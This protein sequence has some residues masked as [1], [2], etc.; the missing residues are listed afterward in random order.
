MKTLLHFWLAFLLLFAQGGA[1]VH[2]VSHLAKPAPYRSLQDQQPADTFACEACL[3]Y[4]GTATAVPP[5]P[6]RFHATGPAASRAVAP[7]AAIY[8]VSFRPYLSRAPPALV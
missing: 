2:G 7:A 5:A 3:A 8:R 6:V 1:L 4:A